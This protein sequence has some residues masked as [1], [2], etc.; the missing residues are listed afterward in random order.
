VR[1]SRRS[2][3]PAASRKSPRLS[4]SMP[5]ELKGRRVLIVDD[6][7]ASGET[8]KLAKR[9]ALKAGARRMRTAALVSRPEA[10]APDFSAL[11]SDALVVFPWD[12]VPVTEDGRFEAPATLRGR[13]RERR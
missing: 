7:S 9:L 4:G 13:A 10:Y 11:V 8:L 3:S 6:V 1:I 5:R 2:R 12:Y